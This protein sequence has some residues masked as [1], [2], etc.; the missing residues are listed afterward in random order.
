MEDMMHVLSGCALFR[1][2]S[3]GEIAELCR[4]L[5]ARQ[6]AY[7]KGEVLWFCGDAVDRCGIVLSGR[8]C[9]ENI[10]GDGNRSVIASH[11]PGAVF[12]DVLMSLPGSVS[13]ADILAAEPSSVLLLPFEK[14]MGG[15]ANCCQ[16]HTRLRQNLLAEISEKFFALR[17][18]IGYLST[19]SLR[20]RIARLL[21]DEAALRR[22]DTFSLGCSR[23]ELAD[24][25]GVNRSALSRE[26]SRMKAEGILDTYRDSF[27]LLDR[28]RLQLATE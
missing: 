24:T 8:I 16:A 7:R 11:G 21:L 26:L 6:T 25:L 9:A 19:R 13:P 15:C 10:S 5:G 17:R 27:K 23:E 1:G 3:E 4:C 18:K 14:L 20:G 28:R 22:S 2:L 12:G